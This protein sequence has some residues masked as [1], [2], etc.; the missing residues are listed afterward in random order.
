MCLRCTKVI[1]AGGCAVRVSNDLTVSRLVAGRMSAPRPVCYCLKVSGISPG[2]FGN[3][4][5][6]SIEGDIYNAMNRCS[7]PGIIG[8]F[9]IDT[10]AFIMQ[11]SIMGRNSLLKRCAML[12][13]SLLVFSVISSSQNG[14]GKP[15]EIRLHFDRAQEALAANRPDVAVNE[16]RAVLALDPNNVEAR[17]NLGVIAFAQGDFAKADENFRQAVKLQPSL[18]K[19]QALL[20]MCEKRLGKFGSAQTLL[21]KSFPHLQDPKLRTQASGGYGFGRIGLPERRCCEISRSFTRS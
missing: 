14:E 9:K 16:F 15:Q 2:L 20:G 13:F 10:I 4:Q 8:V 7:K 21:E 6:S 3:D 12:S 11:P 18:W 19:A 1:S 5:E 17:A